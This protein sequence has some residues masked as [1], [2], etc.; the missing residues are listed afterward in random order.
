MQALPGDKTT[1]LT[2]QKHKT[3]RNLTRLA[4]PPH[5]RR[6]EL[7]LRIGLHRGGDERGPDGAGAD[8]VA[9]DAVGDLLVGEAAREGDDGALGGGVV[10]EV[11]AA[12]VGVHR[13]A[14][15]DGVARVHVLEGVFGEVEVGVDVGVEGGEPLV[16]VWESLLAT[17]WLCGCLSLRSFT[18]SVSSLMPLI[19]FWYAALLTRMLM[20]PIFATAS[21][22]HFWQFSFL[23]MSVGKR[24][25]LPPCFSTASF[26]SSA[27]FCSAGR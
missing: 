9:A 10:E 13:G 15:D 19:M 12:D 5:R 4:R 11:W 6:A 7:V 8:G 25:H 20:V 3:G 1:I 26:V 18:Y 22:T 21:S 27:S 17:N 23:L 24:W 2:R 16:S 14:V